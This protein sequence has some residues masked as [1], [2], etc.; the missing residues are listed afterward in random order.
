MKRSSGSIPSC[1][2]FI[3]LPMKSPNVKDL[4]SGGLDSLSTRDV[5]GST[6]TSLEGRMKLAIVVRATF[7]LGTTL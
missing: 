3:K 5:A 4:Y 1:V 6:T 7:E 2:S